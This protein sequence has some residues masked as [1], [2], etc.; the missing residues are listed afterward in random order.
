MATRLTILGSTGSIGR[1]AL[2]VVRNYPGRFEIVGLAA[3]SNV[4]E[5]A[6]QA[7]EFRPRV[8]AVSNESAARGL[9][10]PE[11]GTK[12]LSGDS[13]LEELA[14]IETDLV[15]CGVVGAIGLRA[16]LRA[17]DAGHRIAL[18]NKEPMIMAGRLITESA[19]RKGVTILPVDSEHNAL[20]QCLEGRDVND[21]RTV[22]LTAY[23]GP[24]YG[25]P[26]ESLRNIS[27]EQATNHP[28]WDM[29]AKISVDSASLMNKGLE[30]IEAMWLFGL[31]LDKIEVLIHPQSIVHGLVEFSDG[32]I[33]AHLGVTDMV[34]PIQF[35]LTWPERV[36]SPMARLDLARL[37][38]LSFAAPD[39]SE[40]P[41]LRLAL[42]AAR[43]GGTA[44]A[45]LNAANEAAVEA[46]RAGRVPFLGIAD[47]VGAVLDESTPRDDI[48][49]EAVLE[50]DA[51]A[52]RRAEAII[53][54]GVAG[55][56]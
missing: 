4:D 21:V 2:R 24:F 44:G 31:P 17:I 43:Q 26:R 25:K 33:L 23:G 29:G 13:A 37:R 39:F 8:I 49:L 3:H 15:L 16:I 52:R 14:S 47:V 27:P 7:Q 1:S 46:F 5:L 32:N 19:R 34:I 53:A 48:S 36:K 9:R 35:A 50:A 41:C 10:P 20:F 42:G 28:T 30:V 38:A 51:D 40:F 56:A 22:Y 54:S 18:A 12:I 11:G 45:V 6:R 55:K